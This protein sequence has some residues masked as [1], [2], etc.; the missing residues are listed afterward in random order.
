MKFLL[1]TSFLATS[2][3]ASEW[4]PIAQT[5][6]CPQD[7][8]ILAKEGEKYVLASYNGTQHK[9]FSSDQTTYTPRALKSQEFASDITKEKYLLGEP[10]FV[11]EQQGEVEG[12][13]PKLVISLSGVQHRCRMNI[14]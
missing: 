13:P 14:L 8:Q 7:V 2:S 12:N 3:F 9:L 4:K 1:I 11:F 5:V 10:T 6:S